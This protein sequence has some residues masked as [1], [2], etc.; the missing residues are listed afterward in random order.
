M[1]DREPRQTEP[2][3]PT[4]SHD[5]VISDPDLWPQY[6]AERVAL[7]KADRPVWMLRGLETGDMDPGGIVLD[8]YEEGGLRGYIEGDDLEGYQ[9]YVPQAE[10]PGPRRLNTEPIMLLGEAKNILA[11]YVQDRYG[12]SQK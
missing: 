6:K 10:E 12:E 11:D 1:N 9:V 2:H 3:L 4:I 8:Y 5:E 7:V